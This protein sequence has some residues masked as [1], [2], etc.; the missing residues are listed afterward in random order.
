VVV[1]VLEQVVPLLELVQ[2]VDRVLLYFATQVF[3]QLQL[4]LDLLHQQQQQSAWKK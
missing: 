1:E 2:T 3:I 4:G